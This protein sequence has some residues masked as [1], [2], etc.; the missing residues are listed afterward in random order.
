MQ[1]FGILVH[2]M[3]DGVLHDGLQ[4]QRRHAE[5]HMRRIVTLSYLSKV[6]P[7]IA[8]ID[9]VVCIP[10]AVLARVGAKD[11]LLVA[12]AVTLALQLIVAAQAAVQGCDRGLCCLLSRHFCSF[13]TAPCPAIP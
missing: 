11:A 2:A 4:N 10:K 5:I 7:R 3:L 13:P 6:S 8:I 9:E 12:D 1:R